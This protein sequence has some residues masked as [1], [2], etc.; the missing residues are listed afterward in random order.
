MTELSE[1]INRLTSESTEQREAYLSR[2]GVRS[3]APQ[4][5]RRMHQLG[6]YRSSRMLSIH[7]VT[8]FPAEGRYTQENKRI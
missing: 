7:L 3:R 6:R 1:G 4:N 2:R 8:V 5:L